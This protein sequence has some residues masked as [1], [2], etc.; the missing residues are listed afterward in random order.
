MRR[1]SAHVEKR[2][3]RSWG[4]CAEE[5]LN[6]CFSRRLYYNSHINWVWHRACKQGLNRF[7]EPACTNTYWGNLLVSTCLFQF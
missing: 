5:K 7:V 6:M 3:R 1:F 2:S 4:T